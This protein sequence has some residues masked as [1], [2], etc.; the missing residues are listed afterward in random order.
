[1]LSELTLE[2]VRTDQCAGIWCMVR[3]SPDGTY[4]MAYD[5]GTRCAVVR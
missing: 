5:T 3:V 1:M 4:S 2:V